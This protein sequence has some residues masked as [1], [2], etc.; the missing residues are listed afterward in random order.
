MRHDE[1]VQPGGP[2]PVKH[3]R[4]STPAERAEGDA[5][6]QDGRDDFAISTKSLIA[7]E[8]VEGDGGGNV[9]FEE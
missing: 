2:E 3:E 5:R 1:W 7:D 9:L 4:M 8:W 6:C